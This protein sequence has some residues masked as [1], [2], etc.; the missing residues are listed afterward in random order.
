MLN[1]DFPFLHMEKMAATP[2]GHKHPKH[3][4][5]TCFLQSTA[6]SLSVITNKSNYTLI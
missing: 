1:M 6:F 4:D 2:A 3:M 5:P